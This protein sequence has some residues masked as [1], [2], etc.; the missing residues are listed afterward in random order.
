MFFT[1]RGVVYKLKGYQIPQASRQAKG[2]A[3]VNLLPLEND[4]K[5]SAM[6]PIKDFEDGKY[7]TFITKTGIVKKTN[8]M[9]YSKIRNGGLCAI[10]LD[11]NDELIRVKLTDNTQ[12]IIIATH[13]GYAIRFNETEV[14]STGRTTRGVMGIQ[15]HDGDY[16]IGAS[17][18]LPDS[19]LL[20]VTDNGYGKKTPLDEYRI[21]SRGGKGI[22]TYRL[23][24]KKANLPV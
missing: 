12:D 8:V 1:T 5:I 14:R 21:Q 22:F 6:I 13:D 23:T 2:T 3:I 4:E 24:E 20:T 18:A 17:V 11:E 15:L 10:D 9:D 16:A 7:A 19:Q